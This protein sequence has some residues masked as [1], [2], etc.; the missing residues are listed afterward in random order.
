MVG[1]ENL[2]S[3]EPQMF[4]FCARNVVE[5][6]VRSGL[7]KKYGCEEVV[8]DPHRARPMPNANT[9]EYNGLFQA[10][11]SVSASLQKCLPMKSSEVSEEAWRRSLDEILGSQKWRATTPAR[12]FEDYMEC[13]ALRWSWEQGDFGKMATLWMSCLCPLHEML[14]DRAEDKMH[15]V[16]R[17]TMYG[18]LAWP[19]SRLSEKYVTL[20]G[21]GACSVIHVSTV[22]DNR[23]YVLPT[24]PQSPVS[25]L[26]NGETAPQVAWRITNKPRPLLLWLAHSGFAKVSEPT[27]S[28]LAVHLS[29][30][31]ARAKHEEEVPLRDVMALRLMQCIMAEDFTE[32]A[33]REAFLKAQQHQMHDDTDILVNRDMLH[34]AVDATDHKV[35]LDHMHTMDVEQAEGRCQALGLEQ[36]FQ[37]VPSKAQKD[38]KKGKAVKIRWSPK[39]L[40][41]D[42]AALSFIRKHAPD[43]VYVMLDK[44]NGRVFMTFPLEMKVLRKSVS[45]SK[46][47]WQEA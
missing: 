11:E 34:D 18:V 28:L 10:S 15:F 23:W 38:K 6:C 33:A 37:K 4:V 7:L 13:A 36:L 14:Y 35:I 3:W 30:H 2:K 1:C 40:D 44:S 21:D 41:D 45:W 39:A 31:V 17:S 19:V 25:M 8:V 16:L 46:R 43:D 29:V 9:S 5:E 26:Q 24:R 20:A 32:G 42:D 27:L 12:E 47:G 22:S